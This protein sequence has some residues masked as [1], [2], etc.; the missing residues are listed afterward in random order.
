V[1]IP[2]LTVPLGGSVAFNII[3]L[4]GI[5]YATFNSGWSGS[6]VVMTLVSPSGR[7][8]GRGTPDPDVVHD[9]GVTFEV[10]GITN[11][12]AG[13]WTIELFGAEVPETGEEVTVALT[14]VPANQPP[15]ADA[16]LNMT[17]EAT[18]PEGASMTL[19][20]SASSD[21]DGDALSFEWRDGADNVVGTNQQLNLTLPLG[22]FTFSLSSSGTPGHRQSRAWA[23]VP[24]SSGPR[25]TKW[26]QLACL[27]PFQIS[28][29][30]GRLAKSSQ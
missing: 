22:S 29:M 4:P 5:S 30:K 24:T 2:K 28:P 8:I 7:T 15:V 16:G 13:D 14:M 19:N 21:P 18:N 11:P 9:N 1:P 20:G 17:V 10:Y 12:E 26:S 23:Q 27:P 3:I 6:D 25:T